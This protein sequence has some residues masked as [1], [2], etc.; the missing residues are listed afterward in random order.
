MAIEI[1]N[2]TTARQ[3]RSKSGFLNRELRFPG[4]SLSDKR[5]E[6]F[7]YELES[8]LFA[9][10]DLKAA[11]DMLQLEQKYKTSKAILTEVKTRVEKGSGFADALE[12]SG[13]FSVFEC[14]TIRIG[15]ETGRLR[16]VLVELASYFERRIK[17]K[18]QLVGVF[19]YPVFVLLVT[20]GVVW[21]M[22]T[23]VVP[24]FAGVYDRFGEDLPAVTKMVVSVA[25]T[26]QAHTGKVLL[27]VA[28]LVALI[29]SLRSRLWFRNVSSQV[30]LRVPFFGGML[31]R[32]Y[33]TRYCQSM[34]LLI[35]SSTPLVQALELVGRMIRFRPMEK[36]IAEVR[37]KVMRGTALHEAMK[38][39]SIFP[40][41]M[42]SMIKVAEEVNQLEQMF[43][44]L[45]KNYSAELEQR[46]KVMGSVLEPVMIL[47]VAA[48]V[49]T[50]AIAMYLPMFR[51]SS[52][53]G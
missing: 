37:E 12:E 3:V 32:A 27:I 39:H 18:R 43:L 13:Q 9:G 26:L 36:A 28:A 35:G 52:A 44:R 42:V 14:C 40:S 47:I 33:L 16:E 34:A 10:L 15:E 1:V 5:R 48:M 8:L 20:L 22:V 11:L 25:N 7:Y 38:N 17:M 49:G 30:M 29:F 46:S 41:R 21:F 50:I 53:I 2:H 6:Q 23:N 51:L 24:M 45:N 19:T 4:R 31:H